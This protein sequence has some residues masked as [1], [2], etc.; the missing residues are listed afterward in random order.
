VNASL[1][2][3]VSLLAAAEIAGGDID[4]DD[5]A[6]LLGVRRSGLAAALRSLGEFEVNPF[7]PGDALDVW[8]EDDRVVVRPG[9]GLEKPLRLAP[10]DAAVL[11]RC[12]SAIRPQ[13]SGTTAAQADSLRDRLRAV[14]PE[15]FEP[16][17]EDVERAI[18]WSSEDGL[19]EG[20]VEALR[21]ACR[22]R[23]ELRLR[24]HNASRDDVQDRLVEPGAV[25]QN[26]GRWYL[27]AWTQQGERRYL[28]LD[29]ILALEPTGRTFAPDAQ[30]ELDA[31]RGVLFDAPPP[32]AW[33]RVRFPGDRQADAR[34]WLASGGRTV[35]DEDGALRVA[36]PT[37]PVLLRALF[38]LGT[39]WT[40]EAPQEARAELLRWLEA[41]LGEG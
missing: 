31:R 22:G 18:A 6:R 35:Q 26:R 19:P 14:V 24:Y 11:V 21:A 41:G 12:V 25:T 7:G 33:L 30:R 40:I 1:E 37:L 27:V 20:R 13:L 5:A 15:G 28:R 38:E 10:L 34:A 4:A 9:L 32:G 23:Q 8:L 29:R 16:A 17:T 3:I 39:D 2:R 36:G